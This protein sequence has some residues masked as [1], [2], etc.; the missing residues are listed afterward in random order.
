ML[1]A[2][3]L[4]DSIGV[5]PHADARLDM[6]KYAVNLHA[7]DSDVHANS[8]LSRSTL[9]LTPHKSSI[10]MYNNDVGKSFMK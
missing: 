4:C 9:R 6:F 7:E 8:T 1:I 5:H 3:F 2:R 10:D